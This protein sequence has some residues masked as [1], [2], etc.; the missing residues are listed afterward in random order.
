MEGVL[1][2]N[3]VRTHLGEKLEVFF[4]DTSFDKGDLWPVILPIYEKKLKTGDLKKDHRGIKLFIICAANEAIANKDA[5]VKDMKAIMLPF[6]N[7][8]DKKEFLAG[9]KF[10]TKPL[11]YE[12]FHHGILRA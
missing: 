9:C 3:S 7:D 5:Y 8:I 2:R 10:G 1:A 11:L 4:K 12:Q 6:M